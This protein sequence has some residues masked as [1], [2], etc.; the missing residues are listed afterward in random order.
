M[1]KFFG[2]L[3]GALL[4]ALVPTLFCSLMSSPFSYGLPLNCPEGSRVIGI[5]CFDENYNNTTPW[6]RRDFGAS[7]LT[8][9]FWLVGFTTI[10]LWMAFTIRSSPS[11][12]E[13]K[14]DIATDI[15]NF[16]QPVQQPKVSNGKSKKWLPVNCPHCGGSISVKSVK[17]ITD[18]EAECPYC[19]SILKE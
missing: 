2:K 14:I 10:S 11:E 16:R 13:D 17:W 1:N 19:A 3:F 15:P 4:I 8:F 7:Q 5:E 9:P 18:Y 6:Y 12:S